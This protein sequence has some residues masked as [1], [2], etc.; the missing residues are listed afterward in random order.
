M[1]CTPSSVSSLAGLMRTLEHDRRAFL[2]VDCLSL[3]FDVAR[4]GL[5]GPDSGALSRSYVAHDQQANQRVLPPGVGPGNA[6]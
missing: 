2:Q 6:S 5:H 3:S 1:F 4:R